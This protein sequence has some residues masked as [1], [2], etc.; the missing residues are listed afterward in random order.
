VIAK[1]QSFLSHAAMTVVR[2]RLSRLFFITRLLRFAGN[3]SHM[4]SFSLRAVKRETISA[5]IYPAEMLF[6]DS[7]SYSRT[8]VRGVFLIIALLAW[9]PAMGRTEGSDDYRDSAK[10]SLL[11][12]TGMPGGTSYQVGLGLASFWTTRLRQTG[13]RVSAAISEGSRENVEAIRIADADIILVDDFILS[14]AYAGAGIYRGKPLKELRTITNLWPEVVHIVV[15]S[16]KVKSGNIQDLEGTTLASGLRDSG[17]R[18]TIEML[19][20]TV[21]GLRQTVRVRSMS[22]L[23][24]VEAFKQGSIQAIDLTGGIPVPAVSAL[25][26]DAKTPLTLLEITDAQMESLRSEGWKNVSRCV[27][28]AHTY[29]GQDKAVQSVGQMNV[30]ATTSQIDAGVVYALTKTLYEGL[31]AL[32]KIHPVFR[33]LAIE[34]AFSGLKAP[35]HPGAVRYY[36]QRGLTVPESLIP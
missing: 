22:I 28:P 34:N 23:S 36:R 18:L 33:D 25:F 2:A 35:L 13:I 32:T 30:M 15:R 29:A 5:H 4:A 31:D 19:L 7:L 6:F 9:V 27:I 3:D 12:A 21:K 10:V 14:M 17:N 16:D 8:I 11:M 1:R 24:A 26:H 20:N